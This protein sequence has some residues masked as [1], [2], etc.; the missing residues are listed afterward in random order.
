MT[1][2]RSRKLSCPPP[3][4]FP[5]TSGYTRGAV[6]AAQHTRHPRS[7]SRDAPAGAAD[8]QAVSTSAPRPTATDAAQTRARAG[9]RDDI[10]LTF[11]P[12]DC[13]TAAHAMWEA[14]FASAQRATSCCSVLR[15]RARCPACLRRRCVVGT[16]A[17]SR[18]RIFC[19]CLVLHNWVPLAG[20][21]AARM[22]QRGGGPPRR[23]GRPWCAGGSL[24]SRRPVLPRPLAAC[25]RPLEKAP[26]ATNT[27]NARHQLPLPGADHKQSRR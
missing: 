6:A 2:I 5:T 12:A 9:T 10:W 3:T 17:R 18:E 23:A 1:V 21:G 8:A 22:A 7:T 19:G 20:T 15:G 14:E 13:K 16:T 26:A 4:S 27:S 24:A 25:G 11:D